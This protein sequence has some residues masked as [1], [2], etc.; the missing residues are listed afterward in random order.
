MNI[1]GCNNTKTKNGDKNGYDKTVPLHC[2]HLQHVTITLNLQVIIMPPKSS[3]K[4][5]PFRKEI[6]EMILEG[7]SSRQISK[8]LK[9][10]DEDI[11]HT[12]INRY[13]NK[14]F[15]IQSEAVTQYNETLSQKRKE[16]G[17]EATVS[18]LEYCDEIIQLASKTELTVN[19]QNKVTELDIKKLGLQA[20][21][22][23]QEI[24]KQG[25]DDDKEFTIK[26]I[27]VD[28]DGEEYPVEAES[29]TSQE[30][31]PSES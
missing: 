8:W 13:R 30:H 16:K 20:V 10:H 19:H 2:K 28:S 4:T 23:K 1:Y 18:D 3:I 17:I 27:G 9:E 31:Q 22:T 29:E 25:G 24:L 5:S 11:S 6:E 14:D 12:T 7:K 15:N 21:K 26:I